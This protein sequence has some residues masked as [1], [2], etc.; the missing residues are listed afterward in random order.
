MFNGHRTFA[1]WLQALMLVVLTAL[2]ASACSKAEGTTPAEK[3]DYTLDMREDTLQKLYK[4]EPGT[5]SKL[6]NAAG[7]GVFSNVGINL[8]VL[9]SGNGFGVVRD[10]AS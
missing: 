4:Q 2:A 9:A 7:Y 10:N 8:L 5:R 6:A 3:R 1:N